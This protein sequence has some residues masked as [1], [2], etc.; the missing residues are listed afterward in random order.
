MKTICK[1]IKDLY[2]LLS[3]DIMEG[4]QYEQKLRA[5][6]LVG[7][8]ITVI[9]SITTTLNVL[10]NRGFVT[11]TTFSQVVGG[12]IVLIWIKKYKDIKVPTISML[13]ICII[14]FSYYI[15]NDEY[16]CNA[17]QKYNRKLNFERKMS[18]E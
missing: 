11:V 14:T 7:L 6:L 9:S 15:V 16:F 12:I 3:R 17:R 10:G 1:K 18:N 5:G 8:A 4:K 13:V 2:I